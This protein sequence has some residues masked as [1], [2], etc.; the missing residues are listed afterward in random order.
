[1]PLIN[2]DNRFKTVSDNDEY[3]VWD[4][5]KEKDLFPT[6]SGNRDYTCKKCTKETADAIT[7]ALNY[8]EKI[9]DAITGCPHG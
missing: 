7:Y 9:Q 8:M 1:M 5:Q 2:N 6:K 4:T 3:S